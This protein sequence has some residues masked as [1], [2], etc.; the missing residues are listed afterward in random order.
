[1]GWWAGVCMVRDHVTI[2]T[3]STMASPHVALVGTQVAR[4]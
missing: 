2:T 4:R 3:F 1:V